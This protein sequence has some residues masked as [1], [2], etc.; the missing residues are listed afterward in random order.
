[1]ISASEGADMRSRINTPANIKYSVTHTG[2]LPFVEGVDFE[3]S[4]CCHYSQD[5]L[6]RYPSD[7]I[8]VSA[9]VPSKV[10]EPFY[11]MDRM[12][13]FHDSAFTQIPND[14]HNP[15]LGE[16][17]WDKLD[18]HIVLPHDAFSDHVPVKRVV[19]G[20][21]IVTWNAS[22]HM[23]QLQFMLHTY[24]TPDGVETYVRDTL[25]KTMEQ[26]LKGPSEELMTRVLWREWKTNPKMWLPIQKFIQ[27]VADV[28]VLLLQEWPAA[29][30]TEPNTSTNRWIT[31]LLSTEGFTQRI[32][33]YSGREGSCI[34]ARKTKVTMESV[35]S[36]ETR[37][38]V[39]SWCGI[40]GRTW[41]VAK[42]S[43]HN[44]NSFLCLNVHAPSGV[45]GKYGRKG[46]DDQ[47]KLKEVEGPLRDIMKPMFQK[48]VYNDYNAFRMMPVGANTVYLTHVLLGEQ[49]E[50]EPLRKEYKKNGS[51]MVI[52][53]DWNN[54]Y[55]AVAE[56]NNNRIREVE[57]STLSA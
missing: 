42:I 6:A 4:T 21:H 36:P 56:K 49:A 25:K 15:K 38:G 23:L 5:T 7:V 3:A 33:T 18:P 48:P 10:P 30:G 39:W 51:R 20:V 12:T 40:P 16:I 46:R 1:M 55:T 26:F 22:F 52:G 28:D 47:L 53:G 34:A 43:P 29:D 17:P 44:G 37:N 54:Q 45:D 41:S 2:L 9:N 35:I 8:L 50:Y 13:E 27:K 14:D 24:Q 32:E 11:N 31:D 19:D 57:G